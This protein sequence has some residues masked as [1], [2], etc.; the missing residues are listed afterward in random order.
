MIEN[1]YTDYFKN[2]NES[3]I[4]TGDNFSLEDCKYSLANIITGNQNWS[5]SEPNRYVKNISVVSKILE[6]GVDLFNTRSYVQINPKEIFYFLEQLIK[7]D[8]EGMLQIKIFYSTN[9]SPAS[10]VLYYKKEN[11]E[12]INQS[13]KDFFTKDNN[14]ITENP[15]HIPFTQQ[16]LPGINFADEPINP[17]PSKLGEKIV[18]MLQLRVI[19]S[20]N[21]CENLAKFGIF[22]S[23]L[24]VWFR[25]RI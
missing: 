4:A 17:E 19:Y 25:V 23:F 6:S 18:N 7:K 2:G 22:A 16:L 3:D 14:L 15:K 21:K 10:I 9:P 8:L 12:Q 20:Q 1:I 5:I 13:V 24:A 11:S